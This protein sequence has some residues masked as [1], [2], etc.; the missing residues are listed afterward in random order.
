MK[1]S[2]LVIVGGVVLALG[3]GLS[4]SLAQVGQEEQG[5]PPGKEPALPNCPI[6]A[7]PID[8]SVSTNT[9]DGPVYFCCAPCIEKYTKNPA[10]YAKKVAAQR[11]ALK[12]RPKVQVS[13]PVS[14]KAV[15]QEF[16]ADHEG[17]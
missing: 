13:C 4:I 12:D 11:E 17:Q 5:Q 3:V 1:R 7:E 6:S 14:G 15:D 16:S 9:D 2:N 8:V 10:K